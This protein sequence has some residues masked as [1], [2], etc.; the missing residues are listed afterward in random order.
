MG[1]ERVKYKSKYLRKYGYSTIDCM[2][3]LGW[4]YGSVHD[5]FQDPKKRKE[6]L[7]LVKIEERGK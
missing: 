1:K 6:M 3:W 4:S 5:A 7:K 2:R